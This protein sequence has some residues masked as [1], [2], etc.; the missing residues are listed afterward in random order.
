MFDTKVERTHSI[1]LAGR[2]R[3]TSTLIQLCS[4]IKEKRFEMGTR[5]SPV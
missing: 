5:R 1:L 4:L 2:F 3:L